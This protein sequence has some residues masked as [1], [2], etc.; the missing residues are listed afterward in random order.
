MDKDQLKEAKEAFKL[1]SDNESEQRIVSLEDLKFAKLGEQW[2]PRDVQNRKLENR[3]CLTI[4]RI[5]AFLRQVTN[6]ARQNRPAVK[7]HPVGD[8]ADKGT[9]EILDGLIRNIEYSSDADVAY[10]TALDFAA[11]MG[12]G[13]WIIRTDYACEDSFDI[14]LMIERVANP[15]SIYGDPFSTAADSADWNDAFV[16]NLMRKESFLKKYPKADQSDFS[17]DG[18]DSKEQ[19]WFQGNQIM[20][21]EYWKRREE[22][23][24]LLKMSD[25]SLLYEPEYL[26]NKELYDIQQIEVSGTRPAKTYK[27]VQHIM[28]GSEVLETN[29][30]RGKYIPIVPVYGDEVNVEGKRYFKSLFRDAKD[31]QRMFNYWRSCSTELVALAPRAPFIGPAGAFNTDAAKWATANSVSHAYIEYDTVDNNGNPIAAPPQRQPFAGPPAGALQEALNASDD[32][33]SIM[34]IYDASLGARSNE[35][36]GRAIMARQREGDVSTF[37]IIDNLSR[38]IRHTGRILI[39]LIPKHYDVPRIIRVIKEDGSN[40]PVPVNQP[41]IERE[42]QPPQPVPANAPPEELEQLKAI[43]KVYDLT[44]GKYDVT[45]S[46]GPSFTTRREEAATQMMEFVRVFPQAAPL[47]GDLLAKNLD[48]PGSEEIAKRLQ[49]MLPPQAQSQIAPIVQQLQGMLQQQ[50]AQ[51]KQAVATLQQQIQDLQQKV[52][53]K[54]GDLAIKAQD[55]KVKT[56]EAETRRLEVMKPQEQNNDPTRAMELELKARELQLREQE[57]NI[58]AYEAET[59]RLKAMQSA[60]S[61]DQIAVL[62]NQLVAQAL[63]VANPASPQPEVQLGQPIPVTQPGQVAEQMAAEQQFQAEQMPPEV[64]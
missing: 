43:T 19:P 42:G 25:G 10:D 60:I 9:A 34:G 50:D 1:A 55:V 17:S 39:D 31:A 44:A 49:A 37:H 52:N 61:P 12:Y 24:I 21:A 20:L 51:A 36:S 18:F 8:K 47:I 38:A 45:V 14:D 15:F 7:C 40:F 27:V 16:T 64:Q 30:W 13:Y 29:D 63:S 46:A 48:W 6:D 3:P 32:M 33:K 28:N 35:T 56:F 4:N 22:Q 59:E 26:K 11:T 54:N 53:D 5:P 2:D 58:A 62:V 23:T 41:V 57:T